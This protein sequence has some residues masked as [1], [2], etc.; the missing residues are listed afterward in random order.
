MQRDLE[1]LHRQASGH[2]LKG[3]FAEAMA[4]WRQVLE[5]EPDDE[6]GREGIRLCEQLED[7][8]EQDGTAAPEPPSE[9][10]PAS[11]EPTDLDGGPPIDEAAANELRHR[12]EELLQEAQSLAESGDADRALRTIDR[13]LILDEENKQALVLRDSLQAPE[14]EPDVHVDAQTD[15]PVPAAAPQTSFGEIDSPDAIEDVATVRVAEPQPVA[16]PPLLSQE[17]APPPVQ[18]DDGPAEL[19]TEELDELLGTDASTTTDTT[20]P[21]AASRFR[22][23]PW[24]R[25][26]RVMLGAGGLLTVAAVLVILQMFQGGEPLAEPV[27]SP[28]PA[29]IPAV[30]EAPVEPSAEPASA[31]PEV[32]TNPDDLLR[33]AEAAFEGENYSAAVIAY[34]RFL[35]QRPEHPDAAARMKLAAER[36]REQLEHRQK[37]D[38]AVAEFESENYAEALRM[39]Y[40]M[41]NDEY[42]ADIERIK[43]NG[44]YNL[45]L[46]ALQA[47]D[48]PRAIGHFEEALTVD[49]T[50]PAVL[51]A[52]DLAELCRGPAVTADIR[53]LNPRNLDD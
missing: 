24:T 45:G 44:W 15:L 50:E 41:S 31:Q 18:A 39:F 13:V 3:E 30:A 46:S 53:R 28:A 38:D 9:P 4:A 17:D 37:W 7:T 49:P 1:E 26:R 43:V 6:R 16:P 52:L 19:E 23:P 29:A 36:Y 34:D 51:A 25:D 14:P 48:C 12:I 2:Y 11:P 35:K 32:V 8:V 47:K 21:T 40:R 27:P 42:D 5:L 20:P 22:M 33:E 10:I